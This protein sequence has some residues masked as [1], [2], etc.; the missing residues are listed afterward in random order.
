MA[1]AQACQRTWRR[2][3]CAAVCQDTLA[4]RHPSIVLPPAV[5]GLLK[6]MEESKTASLRAAFLADVE[7]LLPAKRGRKRMVPGPLPPLPGTAAAAPGPSLARR[8][9]AVQGLRAF[10]LSSPYDVPAWLPGVLM[11]LV[12]L[13]GEPAPIRRVFTTEGSPCLGP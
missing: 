7:R 1:P 8:H 2:R 13:A 3:H 5:T 9:A 11:A 10:V 6:G 12:R 4:L